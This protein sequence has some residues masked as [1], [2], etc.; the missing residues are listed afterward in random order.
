MSEIEAIV[1]DVRSGARTATS[2]VNEALERA[3]N[4][5]THALLS[6]AEERALQRAS[7]VD[8]A[9]KAGTAAGKLVGVPFVAKDNMLSLG[10]PTTAAAKIL[11]GFQAPFQAEIIERLEREGA[12][13]IGK[14]NLDAFAHGGST[15]NSTYGPTLNP[16]DPSRV[17]GGSSGGS[18][19]AVAAGIV[20]LALG[21]DT[22]GSIRQPASFCGVVGYKPTYGAV[23]RYGVVSM[24]S[25]TDCMGPIT[26]TVH[27]TALVME[28]LAGRDAKDATTLPD[29]YQLPE[30]TKRSFRFGVIKEWLGEGVDEGVKA[31]IEKTIEQLRSAGHE[32]EYISLPHLRHSLAVYYVVV[33]AEVASNLSRYDGIRF[34]PQAE[35]SKLPELYS[36]TREAGFMAEN[37]RRILIGNYVL[38]SGYYDAYYKK[39]QQVRTLIIND[40]AAAFENVD[41][42]L[43]PVTPTTAF[44]LGEN[45]QDP[46]K[47]Y[48]ADVMTVGASLAGLPAV[49]VPAGL[50]DGLPVGMQVIGDFK[51]DS[52]VLE[53]AELIEEIGHE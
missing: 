31:V 23:S 11:E 3:R 29:Y 26:R 21:S 27:D 34:G 49:S 52:Q 1:A 40:F 16:I 28:V 25:S 9:V 32:I 37:K 47:M 39:A 24:A 13:M 44:K 50:H 35:A 12:I 2:I 22:G 45:I 46:L 17:P 41:A 6:L 42:L 19:A 14:A 10:A 51:C 43:G 7:E 18:V 5:T 53:V 8:R 20:P 30:K 4:D 38:S 15:E 36:R 48:L 33:P